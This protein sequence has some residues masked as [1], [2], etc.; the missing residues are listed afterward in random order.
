ML[1][2]LVLVL[3]L[4]A[5]IIGGLV[6]LIFV[7]PKWGIAGVVIGAIIAATTG[8]HLGGA[9]TF[10]LRVAGA[11]PL[12]DDHPLDTSVER[13]AQL[14]DLPPPQLFLVDSETPNAFTVG[15]KRTTSRIAVTSGLLETLEPNEL[16]AVLAHELSHVAN[17]DAV[18][19]TFA[20]VPR[21]IGETMIAEEGVVFYL[22]WVVWWIGIPIWAL[23]SLLTL[24]LSRYRE[25]AADRGSALLTGRPETLMSALEKLDAHG[26]DIPSA[27]VRD[28][29]RVEAL[30]I[31][32][33]GG[34]RLQLLSDHPPLAER[35]ARLAEMARE[36]G[37]PVGP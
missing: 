7:S 37:R 1:V 12:G 17:R 14:A 3:A 34:A 25:F 11:R 5:A 22:W 13:L 9:S 18:V 24:A 2:T 10:L 6:A 30:W 4:Y 27:D 20:S 33:T 16:E 8:S 31:V 35:L 26:A 23:G 21:A 19:M 29:G 15:L 32:A 28:L 36:Q